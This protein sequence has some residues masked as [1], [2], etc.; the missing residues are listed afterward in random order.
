MHKITEDHGT[1]LLIL[2]DEEWNNNGKDVVTEVE[3]RPSDHQ[4]TQTANSDKPQTLNN[5]HR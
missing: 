3:L 2:F 4:L 1:G 5:T